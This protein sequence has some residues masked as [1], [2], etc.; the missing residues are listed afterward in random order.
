MSRSPSLATRPSTVSLTTRCATR[1]HVCTYELTSR[2]VR[3]FP[4]RHHLLLRPRPRPRPPLPPHL[5]QLQIQ[6]FPLRPPLGA[7]YFRRCLTLRLGCLYPRHCFLQLHTRSPRGNLGP[8]ATGEAE[9]GEEESDRHSD[10]GG[11]CTV[12]SFGGRFVGPVDGSKQDPDVV[13]IARK[14]Q[15]LSC[16]PS[17]LIN[18]WRMK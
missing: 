3:N 2:T 11:L 18:D 8:A 1:L 9:R 4:L 15:L 12:A 17:I 7:R 5:P 13:P 16:G 10:G 6:L 14:G